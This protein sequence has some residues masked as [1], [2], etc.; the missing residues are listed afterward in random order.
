MA[1]QY[2]TMAAGSSIT[3]EERQL[4]NERKRIEAMVRSYE[5]NPKNFNPQMTASLERMAT[6]YGVMF[7]KYDPD[8][9]AGIIRKAGTFLGGVLDAVA[10]DFIPDDW[11]SS[12]ATRSAKNW[13]KG[14]G[15]IGTV[16]GTGGAALAARGLA[17]GGAAAAKMAAQKQA[18]RIAGRTKTLKG[19]PAKPFTNKYGNKKN[20]PGNSQQRRQER[21]KWERDPEN[22]ATP[23]RQYSNISDKPSKVGQKFDQMDADKIRGAAED[24][25]QGVE[26]AAEKLNIGGPA[27][28]ATV[29]KN[30]IKK[31]LQDIGNAKG[32]QWA[33]DGLQKDV[34]KALDDGVLKID[35]IIGSN[36]LD[37]N[38][39]KAI[40]SKIK[41]LHKGAGGKTTKTGRELLAQV[42][43]TGTDVG[44]SSQEIVSF[45]NKVGNNKAITPAKIKTIAN[46]AGIKDSAKLKALTEALTKGGMKEF[47]EAVQ[48]LLSSTKASGKGLQEFLA[49]SGVDL[50]KGAGALAVASNP[51]TGILGTTGIE[52]S[53]R[54]QME[55]MY[56]PLNVT[57]VPE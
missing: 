4:R 34:I 55:E 14:V 22:Q 47:D 40:T 33:K 1:I 7:N 25:G 53:R 41:S 56:D 54:E 3:P 9:S 15:T 32:W 31:G 10:L 44:L 49:T 21:K 46:N 45:I 11:Y 17:K 8:N 39:L 2:K 13:G 18:S 36:K 38:Q 51:L 48:F 6:Q 24:L 29:G 30:S 12:E 23:D 28:M 35:D 37:S 26:K 16:I 50:A 20:A 52:K 19:Q 43:G 42:K 57:N 5:R 27:F